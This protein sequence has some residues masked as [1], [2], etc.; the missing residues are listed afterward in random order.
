MVFV[1]DSRVSQLVGVSLITRLRLDAA[2]Y[3]PAPERQPGQK[4]RPRLK[5]QRR[6][7]L[8]AVLTDP[9]TV[10]SKLTVKSWYGGGPREVEVSTDTAIRYHLGLPPVVIRWVL[11]RD[12]QG[13][14]EPQA[15]LSTTLTHTPLEI[16]MWFVRRW[17]KRALTWAW[18]R[19]GNG[20]IAP[21]L[22]PPQPCSHSIR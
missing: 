21:L 9:T 4:G 19:N 14:F 12:P 11:I 13:K 1:A 22:A 8:K 10:W 20:M 5:G 7:P 15:L 3:A 2:L 16:L 18:R 6:P 17:K